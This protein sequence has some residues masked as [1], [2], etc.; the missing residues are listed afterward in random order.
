M[1]LGLAGG[2][3]DKDMLDL[4][5]LSVQVV[6]LEPQ[7]KLHQ[8]QKLNQFLQEVHTDVLYVQVKFLYYLCMIIKHSDMGDRFHSIFPPE[9]LPQYLLNLFAACPDETPHIRR[10][11]IITL[12]LVISS[13]YKPYFVPC[14]DQFT[15]DDKLIGS[16]Y[17]TRESLR[18]MVYG[19]VYDLFH[20]LRDNLNTA[21]LAKAINVYSKNLYDENL[22]T[23]VH[24]MTTRL[25]LNLA[26]SYSRMTEKENS[27]NEQR[28]VLIKVFEV[29]THRVSYSI[30]Q[31][32]NKKIKNIGF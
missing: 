16:G 11:L 7:L 18:S 26:D 1:Y 19:V 9:K 13:S 2:Q 12:R 30:D 27:L 6:S 22:P 21:Q 25:V 20:H 31:V 3:I 28:A 23:M 4:L 8:P 15:E 29:L 5:Q 14:I 24:I 17:T 32:G 10:E